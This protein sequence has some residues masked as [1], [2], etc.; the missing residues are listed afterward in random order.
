[1]LL[2][3]IGR[4]STLLSIQTLTVR[5]RY[6]AELA[7]PSQPCIHLSCQSYNDWAVSQ[8]ESL[9][10]D[11]FSVTRSL[12][13]FH[14]IRC[15]KLFAYH[16]CQRPRQNRIYVKMPPL[17]NRNRSRAGSF[18]GLRGISLYRRP[19][20]ALACLLVFDHSRIS[21]LYISPFWWSVLVA[22]TWLRPCENATLSPAAMLR[23]R[24]S[25]P[26]FE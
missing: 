26:A 14:V 4:A 21:L 23:S 7:Y 3:P 24:I 13:E 6:R 5:S 15:A 19:S 9:S 10:H 8:S 18:I 25:K 1:M 20:S 11:R 12:I 22:L 17:G 2:E 16:F